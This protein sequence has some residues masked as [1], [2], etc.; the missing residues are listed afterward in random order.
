M[1]LSAADFYQDELA[2][3]LSDSNKKAQGIG[4]VIAGEFGR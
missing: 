1:W 4:S 2:Q 3:L